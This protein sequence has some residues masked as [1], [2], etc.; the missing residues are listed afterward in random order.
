MTFSSFLLNFAYA[1]NQE[2]NKNFEDVHATYDK[3][4][5][6]LRQELEV[7]EA[8][9][10]ASASSS[11]NSDPSQSQQLHT[12]VGVE[13]SFAHATS[14]PQSQGSQGSDAKAPKDQEL[15][16]RRTEYGVAWIGYMRFARRAESLKAARTVFGKARKD[17][18][19]PWEVYEAAGTFVR[20]R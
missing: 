9:V 5:T 14:Q 19:T 11:Q 8:R 16:D 2:L 18:W 7:V 20:P 6:V 4:L 17:R 10:N 13:D 1:E 3:L 12:P 15:S